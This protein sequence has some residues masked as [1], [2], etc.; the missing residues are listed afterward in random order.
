VPCPTDAPK[1]DVAGALLRDA[2]DDVDVPLL[3]RRL[4][5]GNGIG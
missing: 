3:V 1:F 4:G 2:E 5:V